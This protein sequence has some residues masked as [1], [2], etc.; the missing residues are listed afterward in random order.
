MV[1]IWGG[2]VL[3]PFGFCKPSR[4]SSQENFG[5]CRSRAK[6]VHVRERVNHAAGA[7]DS[8]ADFLL[9]DVVSN[10]S[11]TGLIENSW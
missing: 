11:K 1:N 9:W 3:W 6:C 5:N 7:R 10:T 4:P 2:R 8:P